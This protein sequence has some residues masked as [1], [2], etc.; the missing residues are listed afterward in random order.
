M[1]VQGKSIE[2]LN[3]DFVVGSP[4]ELTF[5]SGGPVNTPIRR[6]LI[7]TTA[8]CYLSF[9]GVADDDSFILTPGCSNIVLED[10]SITNISAQGVS[11]PGTIYLLAFRS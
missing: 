11:G 9:D 2:S 7:S 8:D 10:L 1:P 6:L 3:F 4:T 5:K